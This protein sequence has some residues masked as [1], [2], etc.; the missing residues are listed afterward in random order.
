[1]TYMSDV[2]CGLCRRQTSPTENQDEDG[3]DETDV[4]PGVV[5]PHSTHWQ[6]AHTPSHHSLEGRNLPPL[7]GSLPTP[8][9]LPP[10][11]GE[12]TDPSRH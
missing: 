1:M 12:I 11:R 10:L 9:P 3:D 7:K 2:N 4:T 8:G 5:P 6:N